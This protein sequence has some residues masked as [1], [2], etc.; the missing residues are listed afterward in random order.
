MSGSIRNILGT[1]ILSLSLLA[2][3]GPPPASA[4]AYPP[5]YDPGEAVPP[6]PPSA[7]PMA[8]QPGYWRWGGNQYLWVPGHYVRTPRPAA[9]WVPGHWAARGGQWVWIPG[10][11][12]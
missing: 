10:H 5:P 6:P 9:V 2:C 4:Q 7:Y 3:F 11:W 8:W 12:G 1:A